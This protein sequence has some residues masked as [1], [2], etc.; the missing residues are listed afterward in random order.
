MC[1]CSHLLI[2]LLF[3]WTKFS[4]WVEG[5]VGISPKYTPGPPVPYTFIQWRLARYREGTV[6]GNWFL[7]VSYVGAEQ[8]RWVIGLLSVQTLEVFF[9]ISVFVGVVGLDVQ[10]RA[11][12]ESYVLHFSELFSVTGC[13]SRLRHHLIVCLYSVNAVSAGLFKWLAALRVAGSFPSF[14]LPA[15]S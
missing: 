8:Q 7:C 11:E 2:P 12:T 14:V 6:A 4:D 13:I 5:E 9:Y 10:K 3:V 15:S 1:P